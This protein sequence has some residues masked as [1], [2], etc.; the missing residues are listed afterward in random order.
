VI[1]FDLSPQLVL[2]VRGY[3]KWD[4]VKVVIVIITITVISG[5]LIISIIIIIIIACRNC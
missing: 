4:F 3:K 2:S 1:E 5:Q